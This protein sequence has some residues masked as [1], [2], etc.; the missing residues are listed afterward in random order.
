MNTIFKKP[1]GEKNLKMYITNVCAKTS[2]TLWEKQEKATT[3]DVIIV[4]MKTPR[5]K[6]SRNIHYLTLTLPH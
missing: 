2:E 6:K 5:E 3:W 1:S 4:L